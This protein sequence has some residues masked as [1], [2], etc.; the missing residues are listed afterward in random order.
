M[1]HGTTVRADGA[2]AFAS[3]FDDAS[4]TGDALHVL[5]ENV[6]DDPAEQAALLAEPLPGSG[7]A[8]GALSNSRGDRL[9]LGEHL[10]R[11]WITHEANGI[12]S[13]PD[14]RLSTDADL[15]RLLPS[16]SSANDVGAAET[17]ARVMLELSRTSAHAML[18]ASTTQ[19]YTRATAPVENLVVDWFSAMRENVDLALTTP[20]RASGPAPRYSAE[21][22]RG[23]QP[24]LD[25]QELTG[26]VG[27]LAVD[28]GTGLHAKDTGAAYDRLVDRELAAAQTSVGAGADV[29][30]DIVRLG[31]LDQAASAALIAVARRQDALNRSA[32]QGLAEAGHAIDEI[33]RGGPMGLVSMVHAYAEGGTLRTTSDDLVIALVRSDVE[34]SQTERDDARR[35]DLVTRIEA[36]TGGCADVRSTIT[37]GAGRAP[38]L[39]TA[40]DLRAARHA[41]I[42]AAVDAVLDDQASSSAGPATERLRQRTAPTDRVHIVSSRGPAV[43]PNWTGCRR[44]RVS[45]RVHRAGRLCSDLFGTV[46]RV[47]GRPTSPRGRRGVRPQTG[48]RRYSGDSVQ[49]PGTANGVRPVRMD[50]RRKPSTHQLVVQDAAKIKG[51]LSS[52]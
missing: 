11:R 16:V 19:I 21:T 5:L 51:C 26:V 35:A 13:H 9:T 31:F 7:V 44:R 43:C 22:S 49:M 34:L 28:A 8:D 38:L 24:W 25:S 12:E 27:A 45:R 1:R 37:I 6:G 2:E 48:A 47:G 4:R 15:A 33:R 30:R 41:E 32:W 52:R 10:V 50:P 17:R 40:G 42:R 23:T 39:P 14:L 36:L 18:E 29:R 20:L 46:R 3:W